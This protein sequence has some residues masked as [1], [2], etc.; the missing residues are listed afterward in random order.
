MMRENEKPSRQISTYYTDQSKT[1]YIR[2]TTKTRFLYK[3]ETNENEKEIE[4]ELFFFFHFD[5]K[6]T[7]KNGSTWYLME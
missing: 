4:N 1:T 5:F 3:Y 2:E 7:F 6:N